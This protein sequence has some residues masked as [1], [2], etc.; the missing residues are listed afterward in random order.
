M[1]AYL[2]TPSRETIDSANVT[3]F[4][5]RAAQASNTSLSSF[6]D[7]YKWSIQDRENFW[8]LVWDFC[9]VIGHKGN[10][11]YIKGATHMWEAEFFPQASLNYAENLLRRRDDNIALIFWA[12]DKVKRTLSYAEL[13]DQVSK[14]VQ[15]FQSIGLKKGDR[16]AAYVPNSPES[17]IA[18]LATATLGAMWSSCSPDFGVTGVLD[19]FSQIEPKI[20]ITAD[21]AIYKGKIH[22]CLDKVSEI[23]AQLPTLEQTLVF[24]YEGSTAQTADLVNTTSWNTVQNQ[25]GPQN[26]QFEHFPFNAPLFIMF[27]SGTTGVPKCIVHGAGGTLLQHLKEHQLHCNIHPQDRVFYFT[28]CGWMMWN[29]Q[30]SALASGASLALYD[31]SPFSPSPEILFD[32]MDAAGI[33]LF[34]T[35]AKYLEA[36]RKEGA[37]PKDTHSLQTLKLLTSTGSPLSL[38]GFEYVY[39]HIKSDMGLA[40]IS[41]GTDIISC[42]VLGNPLASVYA[43][44]IQTPG[45]GMAVKIYN[46]EGHNLSQG[47][48]ELV[49]TEAF[50]SMP[51]GFW[52]D[53]QHMKYKEAYFNRFPNIWCHGDFAEFTAHGLIIHGR[54]DAVLNPGGVRIGTAEI[55]R[56]MEKIPEVEESIA[57]GQ[58]FEDDVRVVLFVKMK[59]DLMLTPELIQHI[60]HQI[61]VHASP[62]HVPALIVQ[63]PDVPKTK[64]GKLA[65]LAVRD[66]ISGRKVHHAEAL[67]NP[68][69]LDF[70]RTVCL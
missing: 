45:L 17:I 33:T 60:K 31:G 12:E 62:R 61:R 2:W 58:P 34:G 32:Y 43:G 57:V 16:V 66:L 10:A 44:E 8:S 42:F 41:G 19:R 13:Y 67:L 15:Y 5:S 64:N 38:E 18:M 39:N 51:L 50:P 54:S 25:F 46:E 53:P 36:I 6:K 37:S 26:I 56:Q 35:A 4:I 9:G 24:S 27:S 55:Y 1:T 49:C 63:A 48:G 14:M 40:S 21:H 22:S 70:F 29:W 52:N 23:Q 68:E 59:A 65:E 20:L 7:L 47:K 28:T 11:P 69:S 3:R 30:V